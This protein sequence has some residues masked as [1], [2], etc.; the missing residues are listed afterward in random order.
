M[1]V[2]PGQC[3]MLNQLKDAIL[4]PWYHIASAFVPAEMLV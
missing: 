1:Q 3:H 2:S 4:Y